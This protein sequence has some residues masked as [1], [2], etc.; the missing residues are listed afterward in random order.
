ML[1]NFMASLTLTE[2]IKNETQTTSELIVEQ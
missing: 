1:Y 2:K